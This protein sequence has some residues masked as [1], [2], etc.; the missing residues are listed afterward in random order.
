MFGIRSVVRSA[1]VARTGLVRTAAKPSFVLTQRRLYSEQPEETYE[2]FTNRYVKFFE[3]V[4]DQFELQRGLNNCFA[5]DLVPDVAICEAALR[6][7]RRIDDFSTAVRVFEALKIK[8]DKTSQYEDY[9]QA[10]KPV[11]DELGLLTKEELGFK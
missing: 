4:D 8:V 3:N 6:A 11:K 1:A 7:A 5:Y 2:Q 9:L 10:L